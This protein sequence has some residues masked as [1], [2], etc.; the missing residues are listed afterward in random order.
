MATQEKM[1]L[2]YLY[3]YKYKSRLHVVS[4]WCNEGYIIGIAAQ[5]STQ[6]GIAW[7]ITCKLTSLYLLPNVPNLS[8]P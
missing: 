7:M 6:I 3:L 1:E 8:V 2:R 5:Q 4:K